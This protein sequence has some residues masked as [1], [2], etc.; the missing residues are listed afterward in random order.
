MGRL[1]SQHPPDWKNMTGPRSTTSWAMPSSAAGVAT[2]RATMPCSSVPDPSIADS[3]GPTQVLLEEPERLGA[4]A[5][6]E[7]LGLGVVLQHHLVVLPA[8]AR[9]LV[10]SEGRPGGVQVVAV[11]PHP[12]GLDGP[13]HAVG[14]VPVSSPHASPETVEGVVGDP[15]RVSLVGEGRDGQHRTEDLLLEDPHVVVALQHGRL[16][17]VAVLELPPDVGPLAADQHLG[18]LLAADVDVACDLLPLLGRVLGTLHGGRAGRVALG[19]LAGVAAGGGGGVGG[20][21]RWWVWGGGG[22]AA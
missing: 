15:H 2:T 22:A 20:G 7:V 4:V 10:A 13:A 3:R 9:D 17:E 21:A 18:A 6:Q 19:D 16:V 11:G 8:D 1:P 14:E 12:S 5:H